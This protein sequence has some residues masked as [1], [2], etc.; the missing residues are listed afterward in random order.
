MKNII[1]IGLGKMGNAHLNSFLN[2]KFKNNIIIVEKNSSKRKRAIKH[3]KKK[4]INF[5]VSK[6][7]PKN[8]IFELAIVSTPPNN[9][10]QIIKELANNN[11]IKN[12]L[13]EKFLFNKLKEYKEFS[14]I[15]SKLKINTYVN[16]WSKKFLQLIRLKK[17]LEKIEIKITLPQ[18]KIL[19]NLIH[20][21]EMFK[22]LTNKNIKIDLSN[23][24]LKKI[25]KSYFDGNGIIFLR[26]KEYSMQLKSVKM[27]NNIILIVKKNNFENKKI[28]VSKGKIIIYSNSIKKI[29]DFPLASRETYKFYRKILNNKRSTSSFSNY[30]SIADSSVSILKSF[31]EQK[32]KE[33]KIF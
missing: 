3:L 21:Y 9:R 2:Q 15:N 12:F 7:I 17:N 19:T 5:E 16:V 29:K 28:Y 30:N 11:K 4:K 32:K 14:R 22:L 1:I 27:P 25:N 33:I 13:L 20:F 10:L 8:K 31:K 24:E 26:N 18:K 6:K 23:F